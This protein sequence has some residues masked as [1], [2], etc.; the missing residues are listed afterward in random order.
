MTNEMKYK[1]DLD[2][3]TPVADEISTIKGTNFKAVEDELTSVV[4]QVSLVSDHINHATFETLMT[5]HEL[6]TLVFI[7]NYGSSLTKL[8]SDMFIALKCIEA[9][10]LSG[11]HLTEL[12]YSIG[13]LSQLRYLDLSFTL[14]NSLLYCIDG[15]QELQTLNLKGCKRLHELPKYMKDLIKLLFLSWR[16]NKSYGPEEELAVFKSTEQFKPNSSLIEL[17][18]RFYPGSRLPTWNGSGEFEK[19]V[20]ITLTQCEN[21]QLNVSIGELPNLKYLHIIDLDQVK[22]ITHFFL[23]VSSVGFPKLERLVIDG[24]RSLETWEGVK[25]GDFPLLYE[26][27]INNCPKLVGVQFLGTVVES[28]NLCQRKHCQRHCILS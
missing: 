26:L 20:R 15:L 1:V 19:L 18:I 3:V 8:P 14:L 13:N 6:R 21:T 24:M 10:D 5:F 2:R 12:P 23:G 11:C 22:T 28:L 27:T 25:D 7:G 9:L 16:A 4:N 17:E